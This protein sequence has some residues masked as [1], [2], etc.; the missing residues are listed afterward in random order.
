VAP[1]FEALPGWE[2]ERN[3]YMVWERQ[4]GPQQTVRA[5]ELTMAAMR[6]LRRELI[7]ESFIAA[8]IDDLE[9]TVDQLLEL[10]DRFGAAGGD[11]WFVAPPEDPTSACRLLS[12]AGIAQVEDVGTLEAARSRS[13]G[14]HWAPRR[15]SSRS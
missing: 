1:E 10:D 2:V 13:C 6:P 12:G 4:P 5:T 15:R 3:R 9:Q 11:R 7:R 8:G 14:R